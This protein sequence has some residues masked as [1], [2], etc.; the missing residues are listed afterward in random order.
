[1]EAKTEQKKT[2]NT[3]T[4]A[5]DDP[6]ISQPDLRFAIKSNQTAKQHKTGPGATKNTQTNPWDGLQTVGLAPQCLKYAQTNSLVA[7]TMQMVKN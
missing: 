5:S 4:S 3:K 6:Q 2:K 7:K 1:M